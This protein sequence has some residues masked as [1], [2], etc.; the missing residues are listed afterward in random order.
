MSDF[1]SPPDVS[2]RELYTIISA[3]M[4]GMFLSALDS[5]VVSTALPTIV[6]ELH[7]ANHLSWVVV[8]YLLASTVS[9]P[10]WGKMGDQFGRK[11]I[12]QISILLFL[13]GSVLCGTAHS[14]TSLIFF[15]ALQGL[16][17]GGLLIG[18][19]AII[20]DLV[21]P[22]DRGRYSGF[23]GA[24]FG[25]STVLGPL[26]GGYFTQHV[27]WRW[28]FYVNIPLGIA[29]LVVTWLVLPS[30][31]KRVRHAIDV[32]GIITLTIAASCL[33]M[34]TSLGGNTFA[35]GSRKSL[36]LALAGV[37][38][39]ILFIL[40]E[41]RAVEPVIAPRLFKNK[42]FTSAS[43]VGFVIG[44]AMYGGMTFLPYF[45]QT[46]K[47]AS[48]TMSGLRL[49]PMMAGIFA[50][51]ITA[52]ILLSKGW[53]YRY[54]PIGGTLVTSVG[55]VLLSTVGVDTSGWLM[56]VYMLIFGLGI[57][58]VMQILTTAVQ[59]AVEMKDLG[60]GTAGANFFR[61]IGGSFGTA[62]FGALYSNFLPGRLHT[63]LARVGFYGKLP[64]ANEWTP[65]KLLQLPRPVL[66]AVLHAIASTIHS[67]YLWALPATFLAFLLSLTLPEVTLQASRRAVEEDP[68]TYG[69]LD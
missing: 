29:A 22:R 12:F 33:I 32:A 68:V 13:L 63:Q 38:F 4:M 20:G 56:G 58:S 24:T 64:T 21:A 39:T 27:S 6:G 66:Q 16:G 3:L 1:V 62:A 37:V 2:K 23:F 25:A 45:M 49:I 31:A 19:Q 46:V 48:P 65:A 7:G 61:S 5:T 69:S 9:T 15:R 67:I 42:V 10:L 41:R 8:A 52:G 35:W 55:L 11:S 14:M 40:I 53:R 60:A 28:C 18:S 54:F 34:F 30:S 26:I 59:N 44:F 17:G 36:G 47:G 57:G 43:A 51:S 50:A